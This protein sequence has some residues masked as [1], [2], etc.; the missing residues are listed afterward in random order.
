MY[1]EHPVFQQPEDESIVISQYMSFAKFVSLLN[2][3]SL[4]FTRADKFKDN[5]EGSYPAR[6][7][8]EREQ[9]ANQLIATMKIPKS[10]H[11]TIRALVERDREKNPKI[12]KNLRKYILINCWH[13]NEH[14]SHAMWRLY[15]KSDEGLCIRSTY[16]KIKDCLSKIPDDVFIGQV[17]YIDHSKGALDSGNKL[18]PFIH[19][20]KEY[21]YEQ[22]IRAIISKLS[23][24][25]KRKI[26]SNIDTVEHGIYVPVDLKKLIDEVR[27]APASQKWLA[28]TVRAIIDNYDYKFKVLPSSLD[29][30]PLF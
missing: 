17:K 29:E 26:N 9:L 23:D 11:G 6:D 4:Y 20:R 30:N 13:M 25:K 22:E 8:Q 2:T 5:F 27:I 21:E 7:V 12:N 15:P 28:D 1:I 18:S 3:K 16:K 24:I 19:K 10:Q 14:E